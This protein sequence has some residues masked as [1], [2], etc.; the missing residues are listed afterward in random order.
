MFGLMQLMQTQENTT[1][2]IRYANNFG[3]IFVSLKYTDTD[4]TRVPQ[5]CWSITIQRRLF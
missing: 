4:P 1:A 5:I 3:P 2:G